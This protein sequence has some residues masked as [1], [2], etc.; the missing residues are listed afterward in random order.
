MQKVYLERGT[1][2]SPLFSSGHLIAA[3]STVQDASDGYVSC[4]SDLDSYQDS[5]KS[6][7][8]ARLNAAFRHF[9]EADSGL[10]DPISSRIIQQ[11]VARKAHKLGYNRPPRLCQPVKRAVSHPDAMVSHQDPPG[12]VYGDTA[13]R[14]VSLPERLNPASDGQPLSPFRH[15]SSRQLYVPG[16]DEFFRNCTH[17]PTISEVPHTPSPPSSP[18]SSILIIGGAMHLPRTFLRPVENNPDDNGGV[19]TLLLR[20]GQ[21]C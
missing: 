6:L 5:S 14:V 16:D 3:E 20:L 2:T 21:T 12:V 17:S 13:M 18:A 8:S 10:S 1:Q 19:L 15:V 9:S 4:S 7:N 11:R